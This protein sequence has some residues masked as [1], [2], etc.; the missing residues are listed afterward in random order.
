MK[1]RFIKEGFI[2]GE[3]SFDNLGIGRFRDN[4]MKELNGKTTEILNN[5]FSMDINNLTKFFEKTRIDFIFFT[6]KGLLK[7]EFNLKEENFTY[8][9]EDY[10]REDLPDFQIIADDGHE[11]Y[12]FCS[13]EVTSYYFRIFMGNNQ[14]DGSQNISSVEKL[15]D[16]LK[17]G[18]Q[19]CKV[20][21]K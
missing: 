10:S 5:P 13:Q 19:K 21:F 15:I 18:I 14:L 3:S 4:P 2:K 1:A 17:K 12:F 7:E 16:R 9:K 20:V 8:R 6:L 11:I